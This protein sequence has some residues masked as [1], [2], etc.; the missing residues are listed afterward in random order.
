MA[1]W[2]VR[3]ALATRPQ[4]VGN[5]RLGRHRRW[6]GSRPASIVW[7][8]NAYIDRILDLLGEQEPVEVLQATP[9]R[10]EEFL[11]RLG[12]YG[13]EE[14]YA[15]GKWSARYILAH[16]ADVELAHAFRFRQ[17]LAES[18]P[19]LQ[20]FDQDVWAERY[21][22][23]DPAL[24][25]AAF[26]SVRSWNLALL[27]TMDLDD[28]LKEAYHPERGMLSMDLLVRGLAGHDLNHL[29]QLDRIVTGA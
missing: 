21:R 13:I 28:W 7:G 14:S 8:M 15:P 11:E 26:R 22:R 29:A 25:V 16:L 17:V 5:E 1:Y 24:A 4:R 23:V 10:V 3:A 27:T 12:S 20:P 19:V 9:L 18:E 2:R 6:P